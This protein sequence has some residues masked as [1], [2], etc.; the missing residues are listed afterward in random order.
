MGYTFYFME[1]LT[2]FEWTLLCGA[3]RYFIGRQTIAAATFPEDV[4]R[5]FYHKMN[6]GQR[7]FIAREVFDYYKQWGHIG[8]E[9]IDQPVWL[10]FA[11]ALDEKNHRVAKLVDDTE[12]TVFQSGRIYPLDAYLESP[13]Q[14]LFIPEKNIKQY[15]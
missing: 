1:K 11:N 12:C 3:L 15:L 9:K 14:E 4:I 6:T 5:N 8:D 10:K 13:Y 7:E 2:N